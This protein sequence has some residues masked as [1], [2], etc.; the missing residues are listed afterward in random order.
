MTR[1]LNKKCLKTEALDLL[2]KCAL[3]GDLEAKQLLLFL[4]HI[5]KNETYSLSKIEKLNQILLQKALLNL[6]KPSDLSLQ[7]VK[8]KKK[9]RKSKKSNNKP[10][11][12]RIYVGVKYE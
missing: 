6:V 2:A 1:S 3:K 10:Q 9:V 7:K 5:R 4:Q 11:T 8:L 12:T